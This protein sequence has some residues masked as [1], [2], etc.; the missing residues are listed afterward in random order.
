M[1]LFSMSMMAICSRPDETSPLLQ[2]ADRS[3]IQSEEPWE[4]LSY[5]RSKLRRRG[6]LRYSNIGANYYYHW[7]W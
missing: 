4:L 6:S 1:S 5:H 2:G 7:Y 3:E